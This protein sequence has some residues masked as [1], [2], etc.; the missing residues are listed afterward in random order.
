MQS[1]QTGHKACI[2]TDFEDVE[3]N[4]ISEDLPKNVGYDDFFPSTLGGREFL[5]EPK[6][7]KFDAIFEN[8]FE[9]FGHY[10]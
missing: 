9:V 3:M 10:S 8:L 5:K 6:E 7:I 1:Q 4:K 2:I